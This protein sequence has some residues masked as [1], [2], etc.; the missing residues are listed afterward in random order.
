MKSSQLAPRL[1]FIALALLASTVTAQEGVGAKYGSRNPRTCSSMKEPAK[2]G[3][4]AELATKYTACGFEKEMN[5]NTLYLVENLKVEVGGGTAYKDLP[6]IHRPGG[7]E[8]NAIIY[9]IRG[10]YKSYMCG[11][12]HRTGPLMNTG[13][14]CRI[15]DLPKATGI[16]YRDNFG[17]WGCSLR[18]DTDYG[19]AEQAPPK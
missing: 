19:T 14:N 8:P 3:L 10:S 6:S 12:V 18:G 13:K 4:S 5:G 1:F 17:D 15:Y 7:A 16:C 9:A 2:G 11:V